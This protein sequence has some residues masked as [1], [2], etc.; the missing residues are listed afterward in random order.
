MDVPGDEA[1]T[2]GQQRARRA[3]EAATTAK[4]WGV[5]E[6]SDAAALDAGT[7]GD[8]LSGS[9]WPRMG[10]RG[11]IEIALGWPGGT[12]AAIAAGEIVG[13]PSEDDAYVARTEDK[14]PPLRD[15]TK[16][17]LLAEIAR[18]IAEEPV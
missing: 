2:T 11:K 3:V 1:L 15:A 12:I 4:G 14:G 8:F 16:D 18:R 9:R 5:K 10:T 17:E 7:V 13:P 6:L